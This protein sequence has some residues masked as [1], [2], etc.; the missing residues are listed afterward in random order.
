MKTLEKMSLNNWI[1][2]IIGVILLIIA[3]RI[4]IVLIRLIL[5]NIILL[6]TPWQKASLQNTSH[7]YSGV[8]LWRNKKNIFSKKVVYVG[9][10]IHVKKRINQHLT[11][12]GSPTIYKYKNKNN[13]EIKL[14]KLSHTGYSNLDSL[15]KRLITK[16][17]TFK[18]GYNKTSGNGKRRF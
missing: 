17:N 18:K 8:Y 13:F 1:E 14:I 11:G 4:I 5:L 3:I 2:I 7:D 10:S 16:Y 12:K 15:E 6:L 9:Q